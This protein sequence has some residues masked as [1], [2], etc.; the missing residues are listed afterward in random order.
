MGLRNQNNRGK[1]SVAG[2]PANTF[3]ENLGLGLAMWDTAG[4]YEDLKYLATTSIKSDL[5]TALTNED[6]LKCNN[7]FE[8]DNRL[9]WR[10]TPTSPGGYFEANSAYNK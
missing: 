7:K 3:C 2:G 6:N 10:Q 8:C 5:W 9:M 1:R 4:S